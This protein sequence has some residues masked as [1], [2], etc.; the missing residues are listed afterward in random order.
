MNLVVDSI[1][2]FF[3]EHHNDDRVSIS[4]K[5]KYGYRHY[6]LEFEIDKNPEDN[7]GYY[8]YKNLSFILDNRNECVEITWN[9]KNIIIEDK[10]LL[11]KW[12]QIFE[13]FLNKDLDKKI[14]KIFEKKLSDCY[15]KDLYREYQMRKLFS[16]DL[17][18]YQ[19]PEEFKEN[20]EEN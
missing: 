16:E 3:F 2:E 5:M 15:R 13:E 4:K 19:L 7:N 14:V 20:E 11:Q 12:S 1:L 18:S 10:E 9:Y 6:Y 8:E 17:T